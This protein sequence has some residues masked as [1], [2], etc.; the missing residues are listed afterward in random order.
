MHD[1]RSKITN[2]KV[3]DICGTHREWGPEVRVLKL[4]HNTWYDGSYLNPHT[5]VVP[6]C[7]NCEEWHT[8]K[9]GI[10]MF[11]PWPEVSA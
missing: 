2:F 1:Y 11:M 4:R 8:W 9:T 10:E 3:C 7:W 5:D 6:A